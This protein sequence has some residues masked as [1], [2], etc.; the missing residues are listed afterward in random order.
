MNG[1]LNIGDRIFHTL[2]TTDGTW[3]P[4]QATVWGIHYGRYDEIIGIDVL[5]MRR[6]A[7]NIYPNEVTLDKGHYISHPEWLNKSTFTGR[8]LKSIP[9]DSRDIQPSNVAKLNQSILP[10]LISARAISLI[11]STVDSYQNH[12]N[13]LDTVTRKGITFSQIN[14]TNITSRHTPL[15]T[16]QGCEK[17]GLYNISPKNMTQSDVDA[18][19]Q[20]SVLYDKQS[21]EAEERV[22]WPPMGTWPYWQSLTFQGHE[23]PCCSKETFETR[24]QKSTKSWISSASTPHP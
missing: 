4:S 16:T 7:G 17:N 6:T 3:K 2:P 12:T 13:L 23:V 14:S 5:A 21:R 1:I 10:E 24:E 18:I 8:R 22:Q 19:A 9:I 11:H 15:D 20:W